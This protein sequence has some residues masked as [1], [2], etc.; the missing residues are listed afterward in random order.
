[1]KNWVKN[2]QAAAC[3]GAC[4]VDHFGFNKRVSFYH[5]LSIF[6]LKTLSWNNCACC[7]LHYKDCSPQE[8]HSMALVEVDKGLLD[9]ICEMFSINHS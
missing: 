6:E 4:T 8:L 3:N 1:M 9:D 2:I 5:K 7:G